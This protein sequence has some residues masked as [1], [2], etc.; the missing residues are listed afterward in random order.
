MRLSVGGII[1]AIYVASLTRCEKAC[2]L[3]V[4]MSTG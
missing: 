3:L 4:A 2:V 1:G